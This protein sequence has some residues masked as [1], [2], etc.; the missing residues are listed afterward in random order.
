MLADNTAAI[1]AVTNNTDAMNKTMQVYQ[2]QTK[3]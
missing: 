2:F 3:S 1:F